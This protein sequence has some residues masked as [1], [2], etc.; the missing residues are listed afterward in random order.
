MILDGFR[1]LREVGALGMNRRNAA[2]IMTWNERSAYPFVDDKVLTKRL[3]QKF[4]IPTPELYAVV[5][6]HGS[7]AGLVRVLDGRHEFVV[8]PARG[9]GGS[10][11]ILIREKREEGFVTQS[12][13]VL[14][15]DDFAYH[16]S[17]ILSGIHSLGGVEDKA[18][19]EALIHPDPVF[20]DVT[21]NGGVPDERIIVYRGVPVMAMVRLP[22]EAS[23]GK[24]NLHRGA[25]GAGI[26]IG[27]GVT[28]SAVHR[29]RVV[30]RHPD[31][32]NTVGG[33]RVPQ[34]DRMLLMAAGAT[35]MTGLGYLG[36]D[37][38]L[39][40]ERGPVLLELNA[41]PGLA[42]QIANQTGLRGRL[43]KVDSAPPAV[44]ASTASRV[45]WA[46]QQFGA[47]AG[48]SAPPAEDG[49][50]APSG[51]GGDETRGGDTGPARGELPHSEE[52][53]AR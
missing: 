9:A 39:D 34:W 48:R 6:D 15:R 32:G 3:A 14:T 47:G 19:I 31:T 22:T 26:D 24:A 53:D 46:R 21:S 29:S 23:D 45:A 20:A 28:L 30:D 4:G 37:F 33:I 49:R 40:R 42:I 2:Y 1:R 7:I 16:I 8:K 52:N 35:E 25:I 13:A 5:E 11:I 27:G 17:T 44:F 51:M 43:E 18:I 38:V 10:G 12:G 41:R 50:G 36:A